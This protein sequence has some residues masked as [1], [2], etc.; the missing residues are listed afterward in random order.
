MTTLKKFFEVKE[1]CLCIFWHYDEEVNHLWQTE[2]PATYWEYHKLRITIFLATT[3]LVDSV[4]L[5]NLSVVLL[6]NFFWAPNRSATSPL[7]SQLSQHIVIE[8][9]CWAYLKNPFDRHEWTSRTSWT[10]D[11]KP[12]NREVPGWQPWSSITIM[13]WHGK[14]MVIRTCHGMIMARSWHA[15]HVFPIWSIKSSP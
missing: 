5:K 7:F 13:L 6:I 9:S 8:W 14:I 2:N 3:L 12:R 1:F 10:P 4:C 15:S 11:N